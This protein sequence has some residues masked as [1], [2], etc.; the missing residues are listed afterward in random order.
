MARATRFSLVLVLAVMPMLSQQLVLKAPTN[1]EVWYKGV[2]DQGLKDFGDRLSKLLKE[3]QKNE[4]QMN[5]AVSTKVQVFISRQETDYGN[6]AIVAICDPNQQCATPNVKAIGLMST[7]DP[8]KSLLY[9]QHAI[10][11]SMGTALNDIPPPPI[12]LRSR[13]Y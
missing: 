9:V 13:S 2:P 4:K 6:V 7:L 12:P 8:K 5:K 11:A 3:W 1:L 10:N